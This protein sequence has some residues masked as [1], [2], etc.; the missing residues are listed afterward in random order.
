MSKTAVIIQARLGSTRLPGKVLLDLCGHTVLE[1]V[2]RRCQAISHADVVCCATSTETRDDPVAAEAARVGAVVYRGDEDDVLGRYLGAAE[3]LEAD[4]VLRV[5]ADCPLIDPDVCDGVLALQAKTGAD[6][7]CNNA[8]PSW[9]LGLDCEAITVDLLRRSDKHC[10]DLHEREHVSAWARPREDVKTE[11]FAN[12][13]LPLDT[14]RWTVDYPEDLE[15]LRDLFKY[16]DKES[17]GFLPSDIARIENEEAS[18]LPLRQ[19]QE[20][21]VGDDP[22][23]TFKVKK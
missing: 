17:A 16:L 5:T 2:I 6:Y 12:P 20:A 22:R 1:R 3:M 7:V 21:A 19:A 4:V 11:N 10:V 23:L 8:P 15:Y 18:L 13:G 9:P 14:H